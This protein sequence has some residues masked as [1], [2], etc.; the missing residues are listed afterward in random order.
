MATKEKTGPLSEVTKDPAANPDLIGMD[1]MVECIKREL[2]YREKLYPVWI[3]KGKLTEMEAKREL[4]KMSAVL[5]YLQDAGWPVERFKEAVEPFIAAAKLIPKV[6]DPLAMANVQNQTAWACATYAAQR[7]LGPFHWDRLREAALAIGAKDGEIP[8]PDGG[9]VEKGN[10]AKAKAVPQDR[11]DAKP[12]AK[13]AVGGSK[14][15]VRR[16]VR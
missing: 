16:G 14:K 15:A 12:A 13:K 3:E 5:A 2:A 4:A 8:T 9:A 1:A 6:F 10:D 11:K 7:T